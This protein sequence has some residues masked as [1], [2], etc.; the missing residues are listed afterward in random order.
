MQISKQTLQILK[1]I[2]SIN[3]TV[4]FKTGNTIFNA[5][6]SMSVLVKSVIEE[7]FEKDFNI[8][9]LTN[10]LSALDTMD[11]PFLEFRENYVRIASNGSYC[12]YYY[13]SP[14]IIGE[15]F[16]NLNQKNPKLESPVSEFILS[17]DQI[18][19]LYKMS[20]VLSLDFLKIS[21]D[22][23]LN[24]SISVVDSNSDSQNTFKT[25]THTKAKE[26]FEFYLNLRVNNLTLIPS[27]Y[28]VKVQYMDTPSGDKIGV[29]EFSTDQY[30]TTYWVTEDYLNS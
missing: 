19:T 9:D 11:S 24:V 5:S 7:T 25:D 3:P 27:E 29:T 23:D 6:P 28:M 10:F 30:K 4:A 21:T 17:E 22:K 8:Y 13:C 15:E 1:N 2:S 20:S 18:K 26:E 16:L 14:A 12:D